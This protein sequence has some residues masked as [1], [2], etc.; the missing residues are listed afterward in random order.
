MSEPRRQKPTSGVDGAKDLRQRSD[1]DRI[2]ERRAG[3]VGLDV[4][5]GARIDAGQR[6]RRRDHLDLA[7]DAR[8]GIAGLAGAVVVDGRTADHRVD[9]VAVGE[10]VGEALEHDDAR[11]GAAASAARVDVERP[12]VA[13]GGEDHPLLVEVAGALRKR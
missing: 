11:A 12:A 5:D 9:R 3:A 1:L 2:A 8:R 13:V 4:G 7:V 6:L 10:R